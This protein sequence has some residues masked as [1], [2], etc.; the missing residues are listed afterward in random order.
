MQFKQQNQNPTYIRKILCIDNNNSGYE[1]KNKRKSR[2]A[3]DEYPEFHVWSIIYY[4]TGNKLFGYH[5]TRP[6]PRIQY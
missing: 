2:L 3:L 1:R 6:C 5:K 4:Y